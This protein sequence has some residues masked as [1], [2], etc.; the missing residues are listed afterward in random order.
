MPTL[1]PNTELSLPRIS[2]RTSSIDGGF[3]QINE[4]GAVPLGYHQCMQFSHRIIV[5]DCHGQGIRSYSAVG[6][7]FAEDAARLPCVKSLAD[8]ASTTTAAQLA[9]IFFNF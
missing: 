1:K 4:R 2:V 9:M 6:L 7:Y 3:E 5:A 8:L